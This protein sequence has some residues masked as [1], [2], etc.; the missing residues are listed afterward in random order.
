MKVVIL[1]GGLGVRLRPLTYAIPKPLLPVGE[2]PILEDIVLKL[3][4]FGFEHLIFAVGYRWELIQ[5]YFRDGAQWGV[6]IQYVREDSPM[7]TGGPLALVGQQVAFEPGES[8]LL[9]N[10][11]LLTKLDFGR[12]FTFHVEQKNDITIAT[13]TYESQLPYGEV[14][15]TDSQVTCIAEKPTMLY[16]I[17]TGI[18]AVHSSVLD[19]VP[20][21]PIDMPHLINLLLERDKRIGAYHFTEYWLPVDKLSDLEEAQRDWALWTA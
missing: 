11:D 7:G 1:A 17:N 16:E 6:T 5:T 19:Q 2:R 10:G 12:F 8:F 9:M 15:V 4:S 14:M 3:R 21:G 13:R 20:P 18:Y